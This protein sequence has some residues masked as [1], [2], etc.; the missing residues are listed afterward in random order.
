MSGPLAFSVLGPLRVVGPE[1]PLPLG[2]PK[3][4]CVLAMLLLDSGRVVSVD[5]LI[6]G[7]WGDEPHDRAA[8]TLQVY[9]SNLRKLIGADRILTERPGYRIVVDDDDLDLTRFDRQVSAGIEHASAGRH[10]QAEEAFAGALACW[11]GEPI[12]D[13]QYEPFAPSIVAGLTERREAAKESEWDARLA[14]GHH[15][16]LVA[17][18]ER[19]VA[20]TPLRERRWAQLLVALYRSG[21]QADA[22][23]AYGSARRTL[24]DELG[25]DPGAE[26]R[27]LE[28]A[29][30]SQDPS[31]DWQPAGGDPSGTTTTVRR[32]PTGSTPNITLPNGS[33]LELVD[34]H[35]TIGRSTDSDIVLASPDVSRRHA[36]LRPTDGGG[37]AISDLGSTNGITVN[38]VAATEY[39]LGD[40]DEIEVGRFTLV[41][42][43]PVAAD[44]AN[45]PDPAGSTTLQ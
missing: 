43:A 23:A 22:L 11:D 3:Q 14:L 20:D 21:R 15:H 45:P 24:V 26:L 36:E 33:R 8:S 12:A 41:F 1:G 37:W 34:R 25:I 6:D 9:V 32:G 10:R 16:E 2:G 18:L 42:H 27:R 17:E 7:V 35:W 19:A 30:L 39:Q 4:R 38:G 31:L 29:I 13:L 44:P 28:S 40:G 5:R